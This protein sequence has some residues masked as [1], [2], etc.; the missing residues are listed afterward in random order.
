[1]L[2]PIWWAGDI[3]RPL[4]EYEH[5]KLVRGWTWLPWF[6]RNPFCNFKSVIIGIAH[7]VR[8]VYW[9]RGDGWTYAPC[10]WNFGWSRAAR[11]FMSLPFV[12]HRGS[13]IEWM[14]GWETNGAF[15][16]DLRQANSPNATEKP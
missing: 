12:S 5:G 11:S 9:K 2:N 8:T 3:A 13:R 7:K 16:I 10:G 15:S 4:P 14:I 6:W 1:M